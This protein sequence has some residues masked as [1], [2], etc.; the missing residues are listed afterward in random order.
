MKVLEIFILNRPEMQYSRQFH[1]DCILGS[2]PFGPPRPHFR[3]DNFLKVVKPYSLYRVKNLFRCD[4]VID[5][6][7]QK[8]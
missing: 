8:I 1:A 6:D 4:I 5:A 7:S 2:E 3:F